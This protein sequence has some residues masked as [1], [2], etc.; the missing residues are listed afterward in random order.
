[1][2][3]ASGKVVSGKVV[4]DGAPFEEGAEVTVIAP[5]NADTFE[6]SPEDEAEL[7]ARLAEA[8]RGKFVEGDEVLAKL[9]KRR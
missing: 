6:L 1:M 2:R 8:D 5:E 3:I 4:M 7:L 9:G